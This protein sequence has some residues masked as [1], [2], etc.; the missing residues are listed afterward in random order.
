LAVDQLMSSTAAK[1]TALAQPSQVAEGPPPC[2]PLPAPL[3]RLTESAPLLPRAPSR[4]RAPFAPA[5]PAG[6]GAESR[7]RAYGQNSS[8]RRPPPG[9]SSLRVRVTFRPPRGHSETMGPT[10]D[11]PLLL[12]VRSAAAR[13]SLG[14]STLY[15]L[16]SAGEIDVVHIGRA[17]R[18]PATALDRYLERLM[19]TEARSDCHRASVLSSQP[20]R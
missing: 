5:H 10:D 19:S 13:L 16:I 9:A 6:V 20:R 4:H 12:T 14:R 7:T 1:P 17:C 18:I 3:V 15:E 11:R 2:A 8:S